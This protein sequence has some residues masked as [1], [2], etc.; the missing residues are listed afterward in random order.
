MSKLYTKSGDQGL[1]FIFRSKKKM[2]KSSQVFDLLGDLDL[3]N[4]LLSLVRTHLQDHPSLMRIVQSLQGLILEIGA[5]INIGQVR[6]ELRV[7]SD[8]IKILERLIDY[9]CS[10]TPDLQNF[11]LPGSTEVG[12]LIH[13][14]RAL[15]RQVERRLVGTQRKLN[16]RQELIIFF[17][18]LSDFLFALARYYDILLSRQAELTW[19]SGESKECF[20]R[21][22][23]ELVQ[24]E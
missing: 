12:S 7:A 13:V 5:E 11:I 20:Q 17:N 8:D 10:K 23:L 3:L 15:T 18:R 24:D 16:I 4:S 14:C 9:C 19:K 1:T 21:C 6:E 22:A 2:R